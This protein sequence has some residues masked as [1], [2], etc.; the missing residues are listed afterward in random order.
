MSMPDYQ[1]HSSAMSYFAGWTL[2]VGTLA[3]SSIVVMMCGVPD[4]TGASS[5]IALGAIATWRYKATQHSLT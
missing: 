5:L 2:L 4:L 1:L 3:L